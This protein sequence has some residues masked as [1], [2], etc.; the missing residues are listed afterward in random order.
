[1]AK[2]ADGD[3]ERQVEK[4]TDRR[5]DCGKCAIV[6]DSKTERLTRRDERGE[7]GREAAD[8]EGRAAGARR[9]CCFNLDE[10]LSAGLKGKMR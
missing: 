2:W 7:D 10:V 4:T 9:G 8:D 6:T 5:T 1:M 3:R